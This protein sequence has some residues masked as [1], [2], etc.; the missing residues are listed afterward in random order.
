METVQED[1]VSSLKRK[2]DAEIALRVPA[3]GTFYLPEFFFSSTPSTLPFENP[4]WLDGFVGQEM[5]K[6]VITDVLRV[7]EQ[8][9][10]KGGQ[11][12]LV[13]LFL[14][15]SG[16]GKTE[17]ARKIAAKKGVGFVEVSLNAVNSRAQLI[18][19]FLQ[20]FWTKVK[21]LLEQLDKV[22]GYLPMG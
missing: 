16:V 5:V 21:D 4:E 18:G 6:Q 7:H 20:S 12:G 2:I 8:G 13:L 22:K 10:S 17:L 9:I 19:G 3:K 11:K 14:G 15:P 1:Q